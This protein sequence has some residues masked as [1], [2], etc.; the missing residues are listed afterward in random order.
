M[1][2]FMQQFQKESDG[3]IRLFIT[4]DYNTRAEIEIPEVYYKTTIDVKARELHSVDVSNSLRMDGSRIEKK[5]IRIKAQEEIVVYGLNIKKFTTDAFLALPVDIQSTMYIVPSFTPSQ[6]SLIAIIAI[7]DRTTLFVTFRFAKRSSYFRY[8]GKKYFHKDTLSITLS[9]KLDSFQ[10]AHYSDMTGTRIFST[11][12]ISVFSGNECAN[13]PPEYGFCDH[14]VEQIPPVNTW[15]TRFITA[16]L[17]GRTGGDFFR[18]LSSNDSTDVTVNGRYMKRLKQGQFIELDVASDRYQFIETSKPC[19]VLQF[20]KGSKVDKTRTDP[21]MVMIP[22]IEQ[23]TAQYTIST[24]DQNKEYFKSYINIIIDTK[25]IDGL[26]LD[27]Q[28]LRDNK[29]VPVWGTN[30]SATQIAV[31]HGVHRVMHD[32]PIVPFAIFLYGFSRA[33]SYGYPGGLRLA[34]LTLECVP[35]NPGDGLDNDCDRRIDEELKN[36][37]DDDND[38]RIDE[39]LVTDPPEIQ[40]SAEISVLSGCPLEVKKTLKEPKIVSAPLCSS[41]GRFKLTFSDKVVERECVQY[42]TRSWFVRDGCGN[43]ANTT[44]DIRIARPNIQVTFPAD[45]RGKC[46]QAKDLTVTGKPKVTGN[47]EGDIFVIRYADSP[48]LDQCIARG[49]MIEREWTVK[50]SCGSAVKRIQRLHPGM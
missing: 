37:I 10:I 13:V 4:S 29:W 35:G 17:R 26:R 30:H 14:L 25:S 43:L 24:P 41:R 16:P 19:L 1:I 46:N 47:C 28:S 45:V 8:K 20:S 27:G 38:G 33:D 50:A 3:A 9:E 36:Y 6:N 39:D 12:P 21:F 22:P 44:Q 32:S 2:G 7:H 11:R 31:S 5:G 48:S 15:G 49:R 23:Y 40:L 34:D 42:I 18:I